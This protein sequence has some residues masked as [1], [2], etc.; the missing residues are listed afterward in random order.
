MSQP[1]SDRPF[2]EYTKSSS[3]A[4]GCIIF[5][6]I[7]AVVC[8]LIGWSIYTFIKQNAAID[9]FTVA[10]P[11]ELPPLAPQH[12]EFAALQ[13]RLRDFAADPPSPLKLSADDL[14]MILANE[15]RLE[16][17]RDM[18]RFDHIGD[19]LVHASMSFPLRSLG[20]SGFR[21][22]NGSMTFMPNVVD[23]Q[24][25][26]DLK[27]I[28]VPGKVVAQGFVSNYRHSRYLEN[29]FFRPFEDD[30]KL[31]PIIASVTSAKIENDRIILERTP[32]AGAP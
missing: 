26:M 15:P 21:Y 11:V 14:N 5:A 24:F 25:V 7:A 30:R 23:G 19:G 8:F 31:W 16:N 28:H 9:E 32:G 18:L 1:K 22:L 17:L 4:A 10:D 2:A 13:V 27:S 6:S 3:S 12:E 29:L 20:T